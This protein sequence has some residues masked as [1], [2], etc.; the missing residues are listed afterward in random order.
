MEILHYIPH[1]NGNDDHTFIWCSY[2]FL[3]HWYLN[4]ILYWIN[5][6][7][8]CL[9]VSGFLFWFM[10]LSLF[11]SVFA[12]YFHRFKSNCTDND[13]NVAVIFT[14]SVYSSRSLSQ[15]ALNFSDVF[16]VS[17][18]LIHK[19]SKKEKKNSKKSKERLYEIHCNVWLF[20]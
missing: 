6:A 9:C 19:S 15:L 4:I 17:F 13:W 2:C 20:F 11:S 7:T 18:G 5:L 8:D 1:I 3:Q 12:Q 14:F 10:F 16:Y